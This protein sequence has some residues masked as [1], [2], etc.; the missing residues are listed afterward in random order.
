M[1]IENDQLREKDDYSW[2]NTYTLKTGML[3]LHFISL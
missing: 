1:V 3:S 2:E